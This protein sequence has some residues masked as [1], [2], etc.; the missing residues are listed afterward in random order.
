MYKLYRTNY[1]GK[2][3]LGEEKFDSEVDRFIEKHQAPYVRYNSDF[4]GEK[5]ILV[6]G[7]RT[8]APRHGFFRVGSKKPKNGADLYFDDDRKLNFDAI[9]PTEAPLDEGDTLFDYGQDNDTGNVVE[10]LNNRK[11]LVELKQNCK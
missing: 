8:R 6:N 2:G 4:D 9:L 7:K 5:K 10:L 11:K 3:I 1:H